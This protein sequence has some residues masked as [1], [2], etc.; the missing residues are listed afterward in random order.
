MSKRV[1]F[2]HASDLHLGAP[3]R[4][5]RALSSKWANRLLSAIPESY[6]RMVD[7]AIARDVDF[8]VVSGDIF[9]SARPS[10]GDYLHFFEG[11][12][13]LGEAG[14]PVYLITGN[15]DP[16]T[17]WQH[18]FFSLPPNATMLPGDRPGFALVER[19]G[20]PLCL[21]GGRGYY[22][23]TW[24]MDECIAEGV[25][26]EAAE[27]AL[28]VQHPHAAEAPFAVGLLHTGLNLDPVKAPVDPAVL[29][30]AGMDYWALGHIHDRR[31]VC[32][33]P[34][35]AYPGCTQGLHINEPGEK[36][37]LL[38]TAEA[39]PDGGYA[40]RTSFRPLGPAVW[41]TLDM[42]L[43]GAASLDDWKTGSEPDWIARLPRSGPAAK[44]CL[45]GCGWQGRTELDGLLRK[46]TTCAEL[47]DR[48]REDGSGVPRIWIKDIDVATRPC[49]ERGALLERE[50]LLGEVFRLSE[51]ARTASGLQ[52]L[53]EGPLAPLFAHARA[54]KAL[55]PLTD[56]ELARLLDD[57]ESLCL[58][59]LEND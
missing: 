43:G 48:L 14:I 44:C 33:E 23:Q 8:V 31:E 52:A 46:G 58:D 45:C 13:R 36:G 9:D 56:E 53:R 5:L 6:D 4:G 10:Y 59:L 27:Q 12:E 3:F 40:V 18:D 21:I 22:N 28:A 49:V 35:A 54:G 29:M 24:P 20:Q 16:Y 19:D 34:L 26:R 57:A 38:V 41:K 1:T 2:I 51:A 17:S 39:R 32:R 11:L 15:H 30:R 55:E 25:T 37:C 47:A 7:A 50:D 42:D